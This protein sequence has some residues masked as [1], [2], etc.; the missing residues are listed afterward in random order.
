[1][2]GLRCVSC[3]CS[4]KWLELLEIK[5]ME[6]IR[7][8]ISPH[9]IVKT[10]ISSASTFLLGMLFLLLNW[11][12]AKV[13][14]TPLLSRFLAGI[15]GPVIQEIPPLGS[16]EISMT[17]SRG[18]CCYRLFSVSP[19]RLSFRLPSLMDPL[20]LSGNIVEDKRDG[21]VCLTIKVTLVWWGV[22]LNRNGR[23]L[24]RQ[25]FFGLLFVCTESQS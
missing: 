2:W 3:F 1:M 7:W 9:F 19:N 4:S 24:W 10:S 14:P 16:S 25:D 11:A 6:G 15:K 22:S 17:T 5:W 18:T 12:E 8:D 23:M 13:D 21:L 20:A